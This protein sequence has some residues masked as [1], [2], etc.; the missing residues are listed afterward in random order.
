M[1]KPPPTYSTGEEIRVG[2]RVAYAGGPGR[3]VFIVAARSFSPEYPEEQWGYL[4]S[5]FMVE[6]QAYGPILFDEADEDL[7]LVERIRP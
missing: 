1:R 2:D 7:V 3:V 4:D 6:T 5:G